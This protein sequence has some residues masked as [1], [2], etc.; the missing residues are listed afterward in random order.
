MLDIDTRNLEKGVP[1]WMV[2]QYLS[3]LI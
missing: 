1:L 3:G 2:L